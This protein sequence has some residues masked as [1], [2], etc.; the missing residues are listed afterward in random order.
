M[1]SYPPVNGFGGWEAEEAYETR[2]PGHGT[3]VFRVGPSITLTTPSFM[4][5]TKKT[6]HVE[7]IFTQDICWFI[8]DSIWSYGL[9]DSFCWAIWHAHDAG[10]F[11]ISSFIIC[12][13]AHFSVQIFFFSNYFL[14]PS[15]G[16]NERTNRQHSK[17]WPIVWLLQWK[18]RP[19]VWLCCRHWWWREFIIYS[20][21][22]VSPTIY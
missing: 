7:F 2:F 19:L 12:V 10:K 5:P 20:C 17:W 22:T 16:C 4:K 13:F 8:Q 9:C 14:H 1:G 15:V 11:P 3:L 6:W 21:P 18:G